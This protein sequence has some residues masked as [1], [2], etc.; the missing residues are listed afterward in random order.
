[1]NVCNF[2]GNINKPELRYLP[3][4]TPVLQFS[5][6]ANSG[7]GDKKQTTWLN[8]S[9][10]GKRAETL[11]PMMNTGDRLGVTGELTNRKYVAKEGVERYSLELRVNDVTLLSG[12]GSSSDSVH[13]TRTSNNDEQSDGI[14]EA[15]D[16]FDSLESDV[17]F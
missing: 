12:K 3:D 16:S 2:I 13:D 6:A 7:Y 1:M 17:S 9:L 14:K 10:Y 8:C 5:F 11:A 4:S 15:F